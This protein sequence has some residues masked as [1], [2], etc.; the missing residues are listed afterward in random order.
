MKTPIPKKPP[1]TIDM[2]VLREK[3]GGGS[4]S[5]QLIAMTRPLHLPR[6]PRLQGQ[7]RLGDGTLQSRAEKACC[8][9][10]R[11]R[12]SKGVAETA[13]ALQLMR[14]CLFAR[15]GPFA[16]S[17]LGPTSRRP[18]PGISPRL[19]RPSQREP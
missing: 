4:S 16:R 7:L 2:I 8:P 10:R 6:L 3:V 17:Y 1:A 9:A 12:A 13:R 14:G 15:P 18:N 19:G 11:I 5:G